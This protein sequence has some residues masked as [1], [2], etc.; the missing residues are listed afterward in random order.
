LDPEVAWAPTHVFFER[1]T[2]GR[3]AAP[4]WFG[5]GFDADWD[6]IRLGSARLAQTGTKIGK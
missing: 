4:V 5:E 2:H 1:A 6:E 3:E